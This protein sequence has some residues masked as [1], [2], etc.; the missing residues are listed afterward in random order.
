MG[1]G[2][3][4]KQF[5]YIKSN[6]LYLKYKESKIKEVNAELVKKEKF[7]EQEIIERNKEIIEA[8]I[9]FIRKNGLL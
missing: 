7:E 1:L 8:F 9:G 6:Y 2:Q 5:N 4:K 3:R